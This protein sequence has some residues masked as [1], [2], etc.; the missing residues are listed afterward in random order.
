MG[1]NVSIAPAYVAFY[2]ILAEIAKRHGYSLAI[3][4]SVSR[5]M[6][7]IAVPWLTNCSKHDIL[8]ASIKEYV[9]QVMVLMFPNSVTMEGPEIKPFNRVAYS[10]QI[11]N[12]YYIDLSI[13]NPY[14]EQ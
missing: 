4:G 12:G 10:I 6:D 8:V 11:G 14:Y 9:E 2:P 5:D 3:H 1:N 7:L 13:F